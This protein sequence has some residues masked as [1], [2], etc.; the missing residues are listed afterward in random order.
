ME[1]REVETL[2]SCVRMYLRAR[3]LDG[4]SDKTL[5]SYRL[6][7]KRLIVDLG[8]GTLIDTVKLEHL[9]THLMSL[10]HLQTSSLAN[11]VRALKAFFK[12][13]YEEETLDRNPALK[14][15]EPRL[16]TRIPKALSMEE[17]EL[18]RD[19]CEDVLEHA[20]VEFFFATG[21]RVSEIHQLDRIDLDWPR[22]SVVVLGKGNK[23]REVYFGAKAALW[24]KRY[25]DS[26]ADNSLALFVTKRRR[27]QPC[28]TLEHQR[29]STSQIQRIFKRVAKRCDLEEKVTPHVLRHTLATLLLN[30]GAP[31]AAVQSILGH[32][33]PTTTQIYVNLSGESRQM[34]YRRHFPQ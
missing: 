20:L 23:E 22:R 28:G 19:A 12:W 34:L 1:V 17:V 14:L 9:R 2:T 29:L 31:I 21:C 11:K 26:R 5:Y 15:R 27:R 30:Q 4:Y 25:L 7:L 16:P 33:S 10:T 6:H 13:L 24:L 8:G 18:L 32:A 3:K